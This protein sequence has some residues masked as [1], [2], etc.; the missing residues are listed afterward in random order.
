MGSLNFEYSFI[1]QPSGG[2][3]TTSRAR[4]DILN[5]RA[6]LRIVNDDNNCF[7]YGLSCLTNPTNRAIRDK[8]NTQA[9]AKVASELCKKCNLP[10][11]EPFPS[12]TYYYLRK[13]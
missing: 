2:A 12:Y 9:R 11:N 1:M 3:A 6:V 4:E 7:W 13:V 8:R 5:K 10:W